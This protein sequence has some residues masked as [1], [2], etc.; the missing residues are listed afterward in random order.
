MIMFKTAVRGVGITTMVEDKNG[1]NL[2][3]MGDRMPAKPVARN[4]ASQVQTI[5]DLKPT[6]VAPAKP[7]K[8][9]I[10]IK[11]LL[12][13]PIHEKIKV[14]DLLA[15]PI[16]EPVHTAAK[17]LTP[18]VDVNQLRA[19][20][21][22]ET[23]PDCSVMQSE[24]GFV[25]VWTLRNPGPVAWPAGCSVRF[26]GGDN[27]LNVDQKQPASTRELA[28]ATETNTIARIVEVGEEI[29]FRVALK[30]PQRE[31]TKI[32]YWRLKTTDG[33]A[34]GHRLWCHIN[35]VAKVAEPET[36]S[37]PQVVSPQ[38][39]PVTVPTVERS[40]QVGRPAQQDNFLRT[41]LQQRVDRRRQLEERATML[42]QALE[43]A[44]AVQEAQR[45]AEEEQKAARAQ[46]LQ[47]LTYE[48]R[49]VEIQ[50]KARIAAA[51]V[52]VDAAKAANEV[53]PNPVS[54]L[55]APTSITDIDQ[56][57]QLRLLELHQK[58]ASTEA[59]LTE[60][61]LRQLIQEQ[62]RMEAHET[63]PRPVEVEATAAPAKEVV[64]EEPK[65]EGSRM[66]FPTL[67]KESP[68]ASMHEVAAPATPAVPAAEPVAV[69]SP[70]VASSDLDI[71]EDAESVDLVDS[72][73][74]DGFLT[75]E[76]YDILDAS[77]EEFA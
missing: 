49:A 40:E 22:R 69:T 52:A 59:F 57:V 39:T 29:A 72:S 13:E 46:I 23:V 55:P 66:I 24:Q 6:E 34:F 33:Q 26:T 47:N 27:M 10:E 28:V 71:F 19:E 20:F 1:E 61:R 77:D 30:A 56:A 73:T 41:V 37:L 54:E 8:E 21:V 35:V 36:T 31:G 43:K 7:M 44:K 9:K 2:A 65:V 16:E 68:A 32:S 64:A 70:S 18:Q 58:R 5:V 60:R 38:F 50:T 62:T 48:M 3:P 4:S 63:V 11:D 14:Q 25:Q 75:D 67:E 15:S 42:S 74:E 53:A 45:R 76:E 51:Q 12:A 17:T